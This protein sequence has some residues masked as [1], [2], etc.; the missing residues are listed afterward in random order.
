M[1]KIFISHS[2]CVIISACTEEVKFHKNVI[3]SLDNLWYKI[4]D[5]SHRDVTHL[6]P[7]PLCKVLI[8]SQE[9]K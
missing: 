5:E 6:F 9:L 1:Y 2:E 7:P 8:T 3:V 4:K